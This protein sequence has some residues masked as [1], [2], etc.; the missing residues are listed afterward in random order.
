M[1]EPLATATDGFTSS[2]RVDSIR[3]FVRFWCA[4]VSH[5][6]QRW[7]DKPTLAV[8]RLWMS[9]ILLA[10]LACF[11]GHARKLPSTDVSGYGPPLSPFGATC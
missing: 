3:G 11:E 6:S 9:C 7:P 8:I 10:S 5:R 2:S 1:P 4:L